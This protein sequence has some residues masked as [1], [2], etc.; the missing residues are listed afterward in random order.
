MTDWGLFRVK[1]KHNGKW[2]TVEKTFDKYEAVDLY[3]QSPTPKMLTCKR[4]IIHK[5]YTGN[6]SLIVPK[7]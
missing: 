1:I 5:E 3:N 2:T 4:G 7:D 6:F